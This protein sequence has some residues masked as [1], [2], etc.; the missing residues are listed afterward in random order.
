HD[1]ANRALMG[2]NMQRQA[3]PTLRADKPLVGTGM[4][5]VVAQDSGVMV[6]AKRGGEVDSIDA[7]RIVIRVNDDETEDNESGVD[8]Y[9]LIK[10]ARSNQ[11]TTINQRPIVKP[12]DIV[13]KGDVLADGPSTDKGELA[14]GQNILV[15]FMP[16]NG[17]NFEDS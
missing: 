2:S 13:A 6:T 12:G 17:Y 10:Y 9:N 5:R 1:D 8:I 7:S 4:E 15:A 11:S 16:W 3:V 14:L